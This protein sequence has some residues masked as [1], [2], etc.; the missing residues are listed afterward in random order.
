MDK[1]KLDAL[2]EKVI[3][4]EISQTQYGD[5]INNYERFLRENNIS[6]VGMRF[7]PKTAYLKL[8][9]I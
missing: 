9:N 3:I 6:I 4:V 1:T 2:E 7:S 8:L 5:K